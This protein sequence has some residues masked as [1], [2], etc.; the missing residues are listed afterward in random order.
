MQG[1]QITFR[2]TV[3]LDDQDLRRLAEVVGLTRPLPV[4]QTTTS[5]HPGRLL[6]TE[7][8]A[9]LLGIS[10]SSLYSLRYG[11]N[12]PPAVKVGGRLRWRRADVDAWMEENLEKWPAP[13]W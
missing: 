7:E 13:R 2:L 8:T 3:E 5:Q 9:E 12:A 1:M 10:K 4:A 11:G 6:T